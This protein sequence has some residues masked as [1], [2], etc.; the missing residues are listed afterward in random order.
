MKWKLRTEETLCGEFREKQYS[1][2]RAKI[3]RTLKFR[4]QVTPDVYLL[5]LIM[6]PVLL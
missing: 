3:F 5:T 6:F 2:N 1:Y 4:L